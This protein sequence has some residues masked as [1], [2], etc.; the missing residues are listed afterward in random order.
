MEHS[1]D[2]LSEMK[3]HIYNSELLYS[4]LAPKDKRKFAWR[5]TTLQT[6]THCSVSCRPNTH[7]I[8]GG[9]YDYVL[10]D[11]ISLFQDHDVYFKDITPTVGTR[12]GHIMCIGTPK[13]GIDLLAKLRELSE[14]TGAHYKK[15]CAIL[16]DGTPLWPEMYPPSELQKIKASMTSLDFQREYMCQLTD[17]RTQVFPLS[18]IIRSYDPDS[19]YEKTSIPECRYYAGSDLSRSPEG[20]YNVHTIVKADDKNNITLAYIQRTKGMDVE[21][22]AHHIAEIHNLFHPLR[23]LIDQSL[24]GMA[25]INELTS[26]FNIPCSGF[27]FT[28]EQRYRIITNL[29]RLI[30]RNR[31]T[32][33]SKEGDYYT[34]ELTQKLTKELADI[35][36]DTTPTGQPTY[37]SLGKHDD[38]VMSLALAIEAVGGVLDSPSGL[39]DYFIA[40]E[41][42]GKIKEPTRFKSSL[43][44]ADESYFI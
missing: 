14:Q 21:A 42:E 8:C 26:R 16:D 15:Y 6:K 13:T 18:T 10:A 19:F 36:R 29:V 34:A 11:E 33:P 44:P 27:V 37:K 1:T 40:S 9:T 4:R 41:I 24:D 31:L 32:I 20:D 43:A 12:Q 5:K 28:A 39:S 7:A 2:I 17:E 38:M 35:I 30:E 25:V 3:Q 22:R 23:H